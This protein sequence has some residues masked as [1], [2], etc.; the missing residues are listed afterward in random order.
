MENCKISDVT[1]GWGWGGLR[2]VTTCDKDGELLIQPALNLKISRSKLR[3]VVTISKGN[4][5][6]PNLR[7]DLPQNQ[8]V[9]D[10]YP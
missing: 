1:L 9:E 10:F 7:D 2:N 4:L 3:T 5:S 6:R 8:L